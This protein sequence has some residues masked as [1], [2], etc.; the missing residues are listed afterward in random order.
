MYLKLRVV[1]IKDK[2]F[3]VIYILYGILSVINWSQ[4]ENKIV[5]FNNLYTIF[6]IV[7]SIILFT[8]FLFSNNH[9][10]FELIVGSSCTL[11]LMYVTYVSKNPMLLMFVTFFM[12]SK[13]INYRQLFRIDIVFK[14]LSLMFIY[15]SYR[16]GYLENLELLRSTGQIRQTF[17]FNYPT[18]L[19]YMIMIIGIEWIIIRNKNIT[20]WEI[21]IITLIGILIG[22]IT[23]ARGE[24][25]TL[26]IVCLGTLLI[27]KFGLISGKFINTHKI[28]FVILP[29]VICVISYI[30][31]LC[32]KNTNS[33]YMIIN[34]FTSS[35]LNIFQYYLEEYGVR[36]L[37]SNLNLN[38]LSGNGSWINVIDN[39]YLY[40]GIVLGLLSLFIY[41]FIFSFLIKKAI[42]NSQ[43]TL[44]IIMV[45][46]MVL[47]MVEY[48]SLS[49]VIAL[50]CITWQENKSLC[51]DKKR[52]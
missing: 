15:F 26:L 47:N 23:D 14:I 21:V 8:I 45:A 48:V 1:S 18:Y 7:F 38:Y 30:F 13:N 40:L 49:P 24:L 27:N 35:R 33:W 6:Q 11:Y 44:L 28:L 50:Y 46:Y 10:A 20:F 3:F 29:E 52:N 42:E 31:V 16:L 5:N 17:G 9:S 34:K 19:M 43:Y 32:I 25:V 12:A 36:L 4:Y 39:S 41:L 2:I 37:P 51:I 22:H